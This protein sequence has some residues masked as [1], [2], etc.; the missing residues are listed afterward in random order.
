MKSAC[1]WESK[2]FRKESQGKLLCG[3]DIPVD[4]SKEKKPA[5]QK[6]GGKTFHVEATARQ[7]P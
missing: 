5:P 6:A 3:N 4:L 2:H 1:R 7:K